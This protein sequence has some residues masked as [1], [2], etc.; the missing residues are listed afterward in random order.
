VLPVRDV[1][2]FPGVIAPLFVGR[3]RSLRGIE[4]AS[5]NDRDL[6]I[7]AQRDNASEDPKPEE[8]FSVGTLCR[9]IQMV[10]IPDGSTKVLIEGNS[11][12]RVV[13]YIS[14][15][16]YVAADIENISFDGELSGRAEPLRRAVLEQFERY[17][18]L[19][20]K[21]PIEIAF[22]LSNVEDVF[23]FA[24]IISS[25]IQVRISEKQELLELI[26]PE[27]RMDRLLRLLIRETEL[28]EMEH[29]IHDRVRREIERNNKEYYL[30][31]QLKAIQAELG[32]PD[33]TSEYDELLVRI[34]K[35]KMPKDVEKKAMT[36][37]ERLSK[38]PQMSAEA[39]VSRTYIEWLS[40]LPWKKRSA[41]RLDIGIARQVLDEDHYGLDEVKERIL[42]FL[43]VQRL[44]GKEAHRGHVLC[45]VG[46]PGVGKTSLGKSIARALNRKFVNFSLGGMRDEAEIRGHRR[47][48]IG[49]LPGRIIQKLKQAGV[50][51]PVMLMDEIDKVGTDFRGDPSS[52]LLEVLDPEQN[53]SFTDHFLEVSFDLSQVMFITTANVT[54]TIPRPLQD[55]MEIISIPGYVAEEKLHIAER[56]LWPRVLKENGLGRIKVK[57]SDSVMNRIITEYTREA[58]VRNLDRQLSKVARKLAAKIVGDSEEGKLPRSV[59]VSMAS[60]KKF[61]GA[62]KL[63]ETRLPR[64]DSVGAALGLAWTESGGDILVIETVAMKGS[65]KVLF[66]GNL[67]DIMQESAQTALGFLRSCSSKYNLGS[68]EWDKTDIHVHVP[69]G[70]IPK[71][72]PSAGVTL[73]LSMLSAL[74]ERPIR[75]DI[76]MTGEVTLRGTVLPIGGVREKILAAKRNGINKVILPKENGVDVDELAEWARDGM[77]F[78]YVS[79][80]SEVFNLALAK[81]DGGGRI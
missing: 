52:A 78:H 45:F 15:G 7:V 28:L 48:Y 10:R 1:V 26:N 68:I 25:H 27:E 20:P 65:G 80:V 54:H 67:G 5:L 43:A 60:V 16:D 19:H 76:A 35:S 36:E 37:L 31:E 58:G 46:P 39:T 41:D 56:H 23:L 2:I 71:D 44:S 53:N 18:N 40:D 62:P 50:K 12:A 51:N 57:L 11:R 49:S 72:G 59:S 47:T 21:L 33:T 74:G 70:A 34:R 3:P 38:M 69:E 14:S 77:T 75:S 55:R 73:A 79:G 29:S 24:D 61:L 64:R 9:V 6:L 17:V 4:E 66:T 30:K 63:H 42:E 22:S 13:A 8:L 81:G 32:Q